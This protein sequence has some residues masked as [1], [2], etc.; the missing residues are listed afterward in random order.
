MEGLCTRV[1]PFPQ[2]NNSNDIAFNEE[3]M[4]AVLLDIDNSNNI[5]KTPKFGL[6]LR[7]I[8]NPKITYDETD[9]RQIWMTYPMPFI[10]YASYLAEEKQDFEL[11]QKVLDTYF[12]YFP[13]DKMPFAP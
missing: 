12:T 9:R 4:N 6:K 5:S 10:E 13:I 7:N 8:N 2:V 1:C 11:A 3:I